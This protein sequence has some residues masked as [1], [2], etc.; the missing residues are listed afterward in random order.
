MCNMRSLCDIFLLSLCFSSLYGLMTWLDN[1]YLSDNIKIVNITY[2][3][4]K[5]WGAPN[6]QYRTAEDVCVCR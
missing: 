5:Y 2:S 1:I 4:S 3:D 6:V